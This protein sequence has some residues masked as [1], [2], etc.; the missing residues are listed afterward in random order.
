MGILDFHRVPDK[1]LP[2]RLSE[3]ELSATFGRKLASSPLSYGATA[4]GVTDDAGALAA[5]IAATS[6]GGTIDLG[7]LAY[8]IASTVTIGKPVRFQNGTLLAGPHRALLIS[9]DDIELLRLNVSRAA[10]VSSSDTTADRSCVVV[11][12]KGF[13]SIDCNYSGAYQ[14]GLYLVH[15]QAN[16]ALIRGGK[17]TN[18][19]ARQNASAILVAAGA[20]SNLDITVDDVTVD[21]AGGAPDGILF[22]DSSNCTVQDCTIKNLTAL[23]DLTM[24][25][26][27]LQSGNVYRATDRTDGSTRVILWNGT[28]MTE[29]ITTPTNPA[30]NTWGISGGYIYL[31]LNGTN[32]TSGTVISRIVSAY[33]VLFYGTANATVGMCDNRV[34]GNTIQDV[35][36]FGIYLQMG[37]EDARRN[38]TSGNKIIRACRKGKQSNKLPFAGFGVIGGNE[39]TFQGDTIDTAGTATNKAPGFKVNPPNSTGTC[40]GTVIGMTITNATEN[41]F[42]LNSGSWSY[43]GCRANNNTGH[44][45]YTF[46]ASNSQVID[47]VLQGCEAI[48]NSVNGI[49]AETSSFPGATYRLSVVGGLVRGNGSRGVLIRGGRDCFVGGGVRIGPNGAGQAQIQVDGAAQRTTLGDYDI[50]GGTLGI[51]IDETAVD[52]LLRGGQIAPTVTTPFQIAA[53]IRVGGTPGSGSITNWMGTGSPEGVVTARV[54]S[55]YK[56]LDGGVGTATY[57]KETGTGNTGWVA[58]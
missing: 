56:R 6:P 31:N 38:S 18:S 14:A 22:Y 33:G 41:G 32:P 39:F 3:T 55:D 1:A 48:G 9:A 24:T 46:P 54:G 34:D 30:A 21:M 36:G 4:D 10:F 57:V 15:G 13:R 51:V 53:P 2:S 16:G 29:D 25:G 26:W 47:A 17:F 23:P 27:A 42:L 50:I 12:A 45:F 5:T 19:L 49:T 11:Q 52:T 43:I 20:S 37:R 7:G 44:G 58:K 35:D 8:V 28:E 40:T